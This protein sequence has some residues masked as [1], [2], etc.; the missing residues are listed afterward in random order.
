[1][2]SFVKHNFVP[3]FTCGLCPHDPA[4]THS[5]SLVQLS[6]M[7]CLRHVPY[8][9][10]QVPVPQELADGKGLTQVEPVVVLVSA[11]WESLWL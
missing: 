6:L 1:M 10:W 7:G 8:K 9:L 4:C 3:T 5:R 2:Y 11:V